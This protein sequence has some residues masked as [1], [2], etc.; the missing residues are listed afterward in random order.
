LRSVGKKEN[1]KIDIKGIRGR[2]Y[3]LKGGGLWFFT[4]KIF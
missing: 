1:E 3:N 2:Q 4:K